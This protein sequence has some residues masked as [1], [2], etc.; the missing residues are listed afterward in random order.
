MSINV[1]DTFKILT[2]IATFGCVCACSTST[3]DRES[4]AV[5]DDSA[6]VTIEEP[7]PV[8]PEPAPP[9]P[10]DIIA[11]ATAEVE[12]QK[13]ESAG[14]AESAVASENDSGW[15]SVS[16][17]DATPAVP[18]PEAE[19]KPE[20]V[21]ETMTVQ[22]EPEA[23]E[24]SVVEALPT[25]S[26]E[27]DMDA[28]WAKSYPRVQVR[29][30]DES[31]NDESFAAYLT[32]LREV[33]RNRDLDALGAL[34]DE[35]QVLA[36]ASGQRGMLAM[37]ETWDLALHPRRSPFWRKLQDA[38]DGGCQWDE[39]EGTFSAPAFMF[40]SKYGKQLL[41]EH[42]L[43]QHRAVITGQRVRVR[44]QPSLQGEVLAELSWEVVKLS[45]PADPATMTE[46]GGSRYPWY[47]IVLPDGQRGFCYGKYIR[48][49]HFLRATFGMVGGEWKLI[50]FPTAE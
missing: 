17:P 3:P 7:A 40:H 45:G 15:Q 18:L 22:P 30:G 31:A 35:D 26:D 28:Y 44:S 13:Q 38:V 27:I 48:P 41:D 14:S 12:A 33:I 6:T 8:T 39:D 19:E 50:A 21:T 37:I 11:Q 24:R 36:T 23:V 20:E 46:I 32:Q 5:P 43:P 10:E 49:L 9:K 47:P 16:E 25:A 29:T 4:V 42:I 34:V 1:F 2:V